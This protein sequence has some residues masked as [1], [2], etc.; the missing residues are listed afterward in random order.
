MTMY[1]GNMRLLRILPPI[2]LAII[3]L[4]WVTDAINQTTFLILLVVETAVSMM[5]TLYF[6]KRQREQASAAQD[7]QNRVNAS[8]Q[9]DT[10]HN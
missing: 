8:N 9:D 7:L 3:A 2:A 6:T 5:L 10:S 4:L 1:T